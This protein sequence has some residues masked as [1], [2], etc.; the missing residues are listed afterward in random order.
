LTSFASP[1]KA[2]TSPLSA[3]SGKSC[4]FF[5]RPKY[6]RGYDKDGH[7]PPFLKDLG[8]ISAFAMWAPWQHYP[9]EKLLKKPANVE[10][11]PAV[12]IPP[13]R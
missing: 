13:V 11:V 8:L 1:N 6:T 4:A 7:T 3:W 2:I 9:P 5:M 12:V 10:G